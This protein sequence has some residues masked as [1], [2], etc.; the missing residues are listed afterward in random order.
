MDLTSFDTTKQADTGSDLE[1]TLPNGQL[2]LDEQTKKPWTI[3]LLGV[4]SRKYQDAQHRLA[5][6]RMSRRAKARGRVAV[7]SE[8]LEA[9]QLELLVEVTVGWEH[10]QFNGPF[11]FTKDNVRTLYQQFPWIREQAEEFVADRSNF[12]GESSRASKNSPSVG[13][14]SAS[15]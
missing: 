13:S 1:L 6:K 4:D 8:E 9:D 15:K 7:S 14:S 3:R 2:I 5:N 10:I 11:A 12:L